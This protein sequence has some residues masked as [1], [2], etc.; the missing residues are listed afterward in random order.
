MNPNLRDFWNTKADVKVLK[1]GRGSGKTWDCAAF[2]IFL[3]ANKQVS[4]RMKHIDLKHHF[5]REFTE[6]INGH[7][8][9]RICKIPTEYNTAD[10]GTKNVEVNL[11]KK[12]GQELDLG[13]PMLRERVY[14]KNGILN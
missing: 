6:K 13:M 1:G 8:Q 14:G 3:A 12:H 4:K 5:I 9:G 11:F 2:A 7:Q 10:I